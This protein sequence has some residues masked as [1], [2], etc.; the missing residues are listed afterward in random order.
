VTSE[1]G[2]VLQVRV[3]GYRSYDVTREVDLIEEVARTH[4]YDAFPSELRAFRPGTVPDHPMWAL[5]DELKDLL[6]GRG[7][8][9]TQTPAFVPEGEGDVRVSNPLNTQEPFMR[10]SVLPSLIRRVEYNFARGARDVRFFEIATSFR[11]AGKGS[12]PVEENHLAVVLTGRRE[13]AHWSAA[14]EPVTLWDVKALAQETASR[15]YRTPVQ[16]V[17]GGDALPAQLDP[18]LSF[19]V[20]DGDGRPV[21]A[22]GRLRDGAVD[23]PVWAG[24]VWGVEITLPAD[25]PAEP[26][27]HFRRLPAHPAVE[28]D[29]ALLVPDAVPAARVSEVIAQRGGDLLEDVA[30]FDHYQGEG[31]P[32][33]TRSVAFTLRFRAPDRTL[34]DK[35]VDRVV[36]SIVG[37]LKE[38]LG[39]E[40][41]G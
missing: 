12:P 35:E 7:F 9:E 37:R 21:G 6:V 13:P 19:T 39:V 22:A 10:R 5:E 16:V 34:K 23:A 17:P 41:R 32:A 30:L 18:A 29:L 24:D 40:P 31:V 1:D 3:P 26:V 8:F 33:G 38:E 36:Q 15:A 14:E 2:D 11:G 28:R 27:P 20:L 4:G 25:V